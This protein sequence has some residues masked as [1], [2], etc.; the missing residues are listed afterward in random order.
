MVNSIQAVSLPSHFNMISLGKVITKLP[1]VLN[2]ISK[3]SIGLKSTCN[4][5]FSA[6]VF[7]EHGSDFPP[8]NTSK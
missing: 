2:H 1:K 6:Q 5:A 8:V 7:L 3:G 4:L